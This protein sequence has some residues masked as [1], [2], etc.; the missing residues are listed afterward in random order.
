MKKASALNTVKIDE[1]LL[2]RIKK[3]IQDDSKKIKYST[4]K[5]F[6][7]ISVLE[8]LEKEEKSVK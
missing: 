1:K 4:L 7:N 2:K 8:L 3:L 5:Q 6:I